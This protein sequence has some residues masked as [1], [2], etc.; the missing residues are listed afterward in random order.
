MP[1]LEAGPKIWFCDHYDQ[2]TALILTGRR[3]QIGPMEWMVIAFLLLI[4]P[5]AMRFGVDTRF[6]DLH[7]RERWWPGH[8]RESRP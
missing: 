5:I 1:E 7:D 8:G 3:A 6:G 4:G 2:K